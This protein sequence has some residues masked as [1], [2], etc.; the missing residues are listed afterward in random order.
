MQLV[1]LFSNVLTDYMLNDDKQNTVDD[2][3]E[4]INQQNTDKMRKIEINTYYNKAYKEYINILQIIIFACAILVPIVI[5]N[6]NS[7]L[8]NT[9]TNILV[10]S[11]ILFTIVYIIIKFVDIYMR[12]NI[13]FDKIKIP[14]DREATILQREGTIKRKNNLLSSFGVAC[15]GADC[16][17]ETSGVLIYDATLN[18]CVA[19]ETFTDY[20]DK[21]IGGYLDNTFNNYNSTSVD[22]FVGGYG[23]VSLV[24]PYVPLITKEKLVGASLQNSSP[25]AMNA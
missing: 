5:A 17:P 3:Y 13:D 20:F 18:K 15:I 4:K 23:Q 24:E 7:M 22:R 11:I 19:N 8:P 12:D 2:V 1:N 16:C 25:T 10:M 14:Y 21:P 6:K 9:I